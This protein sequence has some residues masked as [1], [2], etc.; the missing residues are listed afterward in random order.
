[1]TRRWV[2]SWY[3]YRPTKAERLLKR[4]RDELGLPIMEGGKLVRLRHGH[5][6]RSAGAWSWNLERAKGDYGSC[7]GSP[8]PMTELL[9]ATK[10]TIYT[11]MG[12]AEIWPDDK[13]A[14]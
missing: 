4:L 3:Y 12:D 9:K 7:V 13:P 11:G 10:L 2:P 1:M 5:W 8:C 6:Q 14:K